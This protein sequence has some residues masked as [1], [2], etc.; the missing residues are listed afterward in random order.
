MTTINEDVLAKGEVVGQPEKSEQIHN[1]DAVKQMT[2][3]GA[4]KQENI[5]PER[6]ERENSRR[7]VRAS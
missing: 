2:S 6:I 7:I 3:E 4:E 1:A 5:G